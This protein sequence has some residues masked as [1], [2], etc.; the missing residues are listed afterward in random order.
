VLE[1]SSVTANGVAVTLDR[2]RRFTTEL[3]PGTGQDGVAIR[4]AHPKLGV[5]YYVL[6][7]KQ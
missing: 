4:I 3:A 5:H 6:R 1:G 2:H 7:A